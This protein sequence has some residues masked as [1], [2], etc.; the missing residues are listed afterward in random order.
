MLKVLFEL[1][2]T[3]PHSL[4]HMEH[5]YI[6]LHRRMAENTLTVACNEINIA[7]LTILIQCLQRNEIPNP[8]LESHR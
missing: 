7:N 5:M 8:K 1:R 4:L 6:V 2:K 3:P